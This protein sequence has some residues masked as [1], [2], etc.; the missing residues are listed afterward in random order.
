MESPHKQIQKG[1]P[2]LPT[3]PET[4]ITIHIN[5]QNFIN[6]FKRK[7]NEKNRNSRH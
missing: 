7:K 3:A 4:R 2:V 1:K 6:I 5:L